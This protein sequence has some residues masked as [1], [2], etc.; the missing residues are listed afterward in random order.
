MIFNIHFHMAI[1]TFGMARRQYWLG[2]LITGAYSV[3]SLLKQPNHGWHEPLMVGLQACTRYP[4]SYIPI[5][6]MALQYKGKFV[7]LD[8]L[9][10]YPGFRH[11]IKVHRTINGKRSFDSVVKLPGFINSGL[12]VISHSTMCPFKG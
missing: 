7:F 12:E 2:M 11:L 3:H 8:I 6:T 1:I 5:T 4:F 9:Y 10:T